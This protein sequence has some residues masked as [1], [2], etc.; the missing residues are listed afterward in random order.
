[1]LLAVTLLAGLIGASQGICP[2]A[3]WIAPHCVCK[4]NNGDAVMTCS[5]F[6]NPD[7]LMKPLQM[8]SAKKYHIFSIQI[9]NSSLL[10]IPHNAFKGGN[11]ERIRFYQSEVMSL[12]DNDIAFEG[13]EDTLE[14]LRTTEASYV[15]Q[16]DWQQLRRLQ[17]LRLID[18]NMINMGSVD[19]VFPPLKNLEALGITKAG[20][21][22]IVDFAFENL[23]G[24]K[25][26]NLMDNSI[27]EVTRSMLPNPASKLLFLDL[28]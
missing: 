12:S 4:N 28:R 17:K 15:T 23:S 25:I 5:N 16:W 19:E 21:T 3:E 6:Y 27:K 7:D 9:N 11:F 1:M 14:E 18:I 8:V 20:L 10:Y 13:L 26:L 2:P 22:Y 24:L